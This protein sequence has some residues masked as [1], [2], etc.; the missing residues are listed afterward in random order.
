[1]PTECLICADRL[2]EVRV[3]CGHLFACAECVERIPNCAICRRPITASYNVRHTAS[4][5]GSAQSGYIS[6]GSESFAKLDEPC[7]NCSRPARFMFS[8]SA[9][10]CSSDDAASSSSPPSRMMVCSACADSCACPFCG[11]LASPDDFTELSGSISSALDDLSGGSET[12]SL[13]SSDSSGPLADAG[14]PESTAPPPLTDDLRLPESLAAKVPSALLALIK[15][16][17][18]QNAILE[19]PRR[20][21]QIQVEEW[22][23]PA[24][25]VLAA[26]VS[27][28]CVSAID[29]P[30]K[31]VVVA[32]TVPI[33]SQYL[34]TARH[35]EA[36]RARSIIGNAEVDLWGRAEW[37]AAVGETSFL[38]TTPQLFLE[39]LDAKKLELNAFCV[40][41]VDE[42]QHCAG[43]HHP[44]AKIFSEHYRKARQAGWSI[45][46]LG[47]SERLVKRKVKDE[48]EREEALR[49]LQ[50]AMESRVLRF[51]P[52]AEKPAASSCLVETLRGLRLWALRL[53]G[54][55]TSRVLYEGPDDGQ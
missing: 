3:Q 39:A 1:M 33:V 21:F 53:R 9:P 15:L 25:T 50:K 13:D 28:R 22:A 20:S 18:C 44:F 7:S 42:C 17:E 47:L 40:L 43:S 51:Q 49:K 41:V 11:T 2:S 48:A 12:A 27:T 46:V 24:K 37:Q 23:I 5:R 29:F 52:G 45:R 38:V 8:C 6:S 14:T 4:A 32:P 55:A 19:L 10:F 30:R 26:A 35:W 16:C 54:R 36:L 34:V 31:A